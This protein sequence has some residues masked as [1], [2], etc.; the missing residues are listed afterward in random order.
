MVAP[1]RIM[2]AVVHN[3]A[4]AGDPG[5]LCKGRKSCGKLHRIQDRRNEAITGVGVCVQ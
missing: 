2:H 3:V 4:V 5:S 1:K